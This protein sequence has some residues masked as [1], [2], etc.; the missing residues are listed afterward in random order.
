MASRKCSRSLC[1]FFRSLIE[2]V[3]QDGGFSGSPPPPATQLFCVETPAVGRG[4]GALLWPD[5]RSLPYEGGAT[6]FADC[7]LAYRLLE[8]AAAALADSL[9][10]LYWEGGVFGRT[11][12]CVMGEK[13]PRMEPAGLRP[14]QPPSFPDGPPSEAELQEEKS[15]MG[16]STFKSKTGWKGSGAQSVHPLVWRHPDTGEKAVMVHTLIMEALRNRDDG[17]VYSWEESEAIVAEMLA[18]ATQPE[19]VYC[20]N[21]TA[22]DLVVWD[23]FTSFHTITPYDDYKEAEEPRLMHR[24]SL[25]GDFQP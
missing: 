7:R 9:D 21:W 12:V 23:N 18:G 20:H 16:L 5:G 1:V 19:H 6:V 3:A 22:G 14:L 8:P 17:T 2:A 24:I 4:S 25:T 11:N 13:Y 15:R 10:V